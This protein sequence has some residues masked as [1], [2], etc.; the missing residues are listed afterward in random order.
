MHHPNVVL[1]GQSLDEGSS[2]N[3]RPLSSLTTPCKARVVAGAVTGAVWV[4][5]RY[6]TSR[7]VCSWVQLYDRVVEERQRHVD[8]F[9]KLARN[10]D[11]KGTEAALSA[12]GGVPINARNSQVGRCGVQ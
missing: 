9:V 4:S 7:T 5:R 3:E 10:G 12:G 2:C 11:V 8:D 1:R 6:L